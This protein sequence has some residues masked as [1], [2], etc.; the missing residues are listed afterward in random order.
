[1]L[2]ITKLNAINWLKFA[3]IIYPFQKEEREQI[4]FFIYKMKRKLRDKILEDVYGGD[5][6]SN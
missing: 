2:K 3:L 5:D 6:E 1:M 4:E